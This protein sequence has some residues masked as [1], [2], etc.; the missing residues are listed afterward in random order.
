MLLK[1]LVRALVFFFLLTPLYYTFFVAQVTPTVVAEEGQEQVVDQGD[2]RYSIKEGDELFSITAEKLSGVEKMIT[3]DNSTFGS[4]YIALR[5]AGSAEVLI[6]KD[7]TYSAFSQ[8]SSIILDDFL[9]TNPAFDYSVRSSLS[10]IGDRFGMASDPVALIAKQRATD[11]GVGFMKLFGSVLLMIILLIF[12]LRMQ[13]G[14]ITNTIDMF[15]PENIDDDID[16]LVGMNDIKRELLQLEEMISSRELYKEYGVDKPFN[17]MMTGP[18]GTGKTKIARCLAKRLN[19]PMFYASA[20]SL[21]SGYVGGGPRTLKKLYQ[22]ALKQKRAIIFLDEAESVLLTR[23]RQTNSKYD[24]DTTTS[25]LSLLDGVNTK[26]GVEIIWVVASNFDEHKMVMDE[27]MLRRFHLKINFRLP[28]HEERREIMRRL[29]AKRTDDK[30]CDKVD[31][32]HIAGITNGMSP[33]IL[34]TLIA[35]ASLMAVQGLKKIDQSTLLEAFERVAG[36]LTDRATTDKMNNKRNIIAV[37]EAGHFLM[38]VHHAMIELKGDASKLYDNLNVIKISTESVSK[39]GALGFVLSKTEDVPLQTRRDYEQKICELYGGMANEEI[40]Y[41]EAGVTAG[42]HNDIQKVTEMLNVMFNEVGYYNS[43]KLNYGMLS[44]MG[45]DTHGARIEQI[46]EKAAELFEQTTIV[47][48]MYG[49]LSD[50][51]VTLL[52]NQYVMTL[53]DV[54]PYLHRFF[55]DHV[56]IAASYSPTLKEVAA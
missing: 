6:Y 29:L 35:R 25:L 55:D 47:L 51:I 23:Q 2:K 44:K 32:N 3:I 10:G 34:E 53:D 8:Y 5:F 20:S 13:S 19:I 16:D 11:A 43:C 27:A 41:K 9:K 15:K 37:H 30:V 14:S 31:L 1:M 28:N 33:A 54:I 46:E 45:Y 12:L 21:E 24:N 36:G 39:L 56:E 50:T 52:M 22:R 48:A 42:A 26:K 49:E 7:V 17:V 4:R 18:A 38:Q 40:Y